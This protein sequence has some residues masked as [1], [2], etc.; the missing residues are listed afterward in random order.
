MKF[1]QPSEEDL[2]EG[3]FQMLLSNIQKFQMSMVGVE[4]IV[5]QKHLGESCYVSTLQL[6][7]ES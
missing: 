3:L 4:C 5:R 1:H 2:G 6:M 7:Y